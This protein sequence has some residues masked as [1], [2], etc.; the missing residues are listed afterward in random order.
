[1]YIK[2][3]TINSIGVFDEQ[4][5]PCYFEDSDYCYTAKTKGIQTIVTPNSIIYHYEGATAGSDTAT[6]F[7][8]YQ[9]INQQKFLDKHR[10]QLRG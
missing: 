2:R 10:N 6:G 3:T 1:M 4:F 5:H 7:K 8:R 9:L